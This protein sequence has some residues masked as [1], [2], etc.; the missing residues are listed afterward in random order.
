[1]IGLKTGMFKTNYSID[2]KKKKLTK[3]KLKNNEKE[4]NERSNEFFVTTSHDK[5][6]IDKKSLESSLETKRSFYINECL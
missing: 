1:M 5:H 2:S 4:L 3:I 6:Q